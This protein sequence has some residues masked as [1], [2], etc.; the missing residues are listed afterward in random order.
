MIEEREPIL[1]NVMRECCWLRFDM[2]NELVFLHPQ[3]VQAYK[4]ACE[5]LAR[6]G[7]LKLSGDEPGWYRIVA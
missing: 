1:L 3:G 5:Y 6:R 7:F 2:V 4:E